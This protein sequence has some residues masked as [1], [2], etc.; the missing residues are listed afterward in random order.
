MG[1]LTPARVV[2]LR[3]R[4]A[5]ERSVLV[6]TSLLMVVQ[7]N[8]SLFCLDRRT[9]FC[10]FSDRY[11]L[12]ILLFDWFHSQFAICKNSSADIYL[13]RSLGMVDML[14]MLLYT[15]LI[16][17][18]FLYDNVTLHDLRVGSE[19]IVFCLR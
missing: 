7:T 17:Y 3:R 9:Y 18:A 16:R 5:D 1:D 12:L 19:P 8:S 13:P 2:M 15:R 10:F 14:K 4:S 11:I 6:R